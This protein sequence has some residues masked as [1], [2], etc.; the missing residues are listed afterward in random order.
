MNNLIKRIYFNLIFYV[1]RVTG[2]KK[3]RLYNHLFS[4]GF[5]GDKY[6]ID[7]MFKLLIKAG[8]FIET[9]SQE[10]H[11]ICH[12][13]REFPELK[14]FS[15]EG[16]RK[17]YAIA[18]K[19]LKSQNSNNVRLIHTLSPQFLYGLQTENPDITDS[20]A[21]F[22]LDAHG[23]GFEWPLRDELKHILANY[24][25]CHIVIDD[26]KVPN[27]SQ[28][29][30]DSYNN[31]ECSLE[32]IGDILSSHKDIKIYLPNYSEVTSDYNPL[33]G[34]VCIQVGNSKSMISDLAFIDR[35]K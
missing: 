2:N 23:F 11:S 13:A 15:C 28:F 6:L 24:K 12:V 9:G 17:A 32:Y 4:S 22:W 5:H 16:D 8:L 27:R 14:C 10:G 7:F 29:G 1:K 19:N 18:K 21:V 35:Y 3:K 30:Y 26:F 33:R 31:Q 25:N 34:W 20:N